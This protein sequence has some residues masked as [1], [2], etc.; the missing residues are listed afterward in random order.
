MNSKNKVFKYNHQS[1]VTLAELMVPSNANFSGKIHGGYIL[2]LMDKVAYASA[3]KHSE[4]YCVTANIGGVDFLNPVEVGELLTLRAKVNYVGT[5]SM[6]VGIR[7]ESQ[8]IVTGV[9]KHCNSSFFTMVAVGEDGEKVKVPGLILDSEEDIRR[10]ARSK[11][12]IE[13]KQSRKKEYDDNSF[14]IEDHL[15]EL[16]D[17]NVIIEL[18]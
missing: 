5:S 3:C 6:V 11:T 9:S 13:Q 7:V 8:N 1:E 14:S 15:A 4:R 12:R 2:S 18:L 10:F 17:Q 16:Q